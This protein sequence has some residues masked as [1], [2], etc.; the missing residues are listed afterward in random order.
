MIKHHNRS[1]FLWRDP[2][3][4]KD[5]K[6]NKDFVTRLKIEE[7]LLQKNIQSKEHRLIKFNNPENAYK[8]KET[9]IIVQYDCCPDGSV[10]TTTV[11]EYKRA[12]TGGLPC[13][14][15]KARKQ[16][17]LLKQHFISVSVK[18]RVQTK[19]KS[20]LELI[21]TNGHIF[22][23]YENTET[24]K[25]Q[26]TLIKVECHQC[27]TKKGVIQVVSVKNY[28]RNAKGLTCCF[29]KEGKQLRV[30][31]QSQKLRSLSESEENNSEKEG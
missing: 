31:G 9:E 18:E 11:H 15:D 19:G 8:N 17:S 6:I 4:Q 14:L 2:L 5:E 27:A 10:H 28:C 23:G 21:K 30:L 12:N 16:L 25:N 20:V 26:N 13:C 22:H 29:L 1:D 7:N 24:Y 3:T